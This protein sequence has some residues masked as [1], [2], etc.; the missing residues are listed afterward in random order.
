MPLSYSPINSLLRNIQDTKEIAGVYQPITPMIPKPIRPIKLLFLSILLA[1]CNS[2]PSSVSSERVEGTEEDIIDIYKPKIL[3]QEI[4]TLCW[5]NI[6]P[7]NAYKTDGKYGLTNEYKYILTPPVYDTIIGM[8]HQYC[9]AIKNGYAS[10]VTLKGEELISPKIEYFTYDTQDSLFYIVDSIGLVSYFDINKK[11]EIYPLMPFYLKSK[12]KRHSLRDKFCL[13]NCVGTQLTE[14]YD[15]IHPMVKGKALAKKDSLIGFIDTKGIFTPI[16]SY[17]G[18]Q[19]TRY[20]DQ[21]YFITPP[22]KQG[23]LDSCYNEII[24]IEYESISLAKLDDNILIVKKGEKY[25]IIGLNGENILPFEYDLIEGDKDCSLLITK[26]GAHY[27]LISTGLRADQTTSSQY[28][29]ITF[30]TQLQSAGGGSCFTW[31]DKKANELC[32]SRGCYKAIG[33]KI[34]HDGK[35]FLL[36]RFGEKETINDSK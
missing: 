28:D 33:Y 5:G 24:P 32:F 14:W 31:E 15:E 19:I 23:M 25:G 7:I 13:A 36:D 17:K 21:Y 12:E 4:E 1:G 35:V 22:N 3:P 30:R 34:E 20:K 8:N 26:K 10:I 27:T 16:P 11:R 9:Y 18:A 2:T 6:R 29:K